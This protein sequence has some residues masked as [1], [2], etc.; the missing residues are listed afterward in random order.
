MGRIQFTLCGSCSSEEELN[1]Y[2]AT[3]PPVRQEILSLIN[4]RP[5]TPEEIAHRLGLPRE[6]VLAHLEG[7][8][9]PGLVERAGL[10]YKPSFAIFTAEDQAKL[11]PLIDKLSSVFAE[12]VEQNI[13]RVRSTYQ[14]CGFQEHGLSFGDMAYILVGAYTLDYG[15][16]KFL[17][18]AGFLVVSKPMPG[19]NYIFSG[20]E[21]GP[22]LRANWQWGHSRKFGKFTFFGHGELPQEGPR[23]AFP[24]QAY[25][26]LKGGHPEEEVAATMEELGQILL[27]LYEGPLGM[28]ELLERTGLGK[29]EFE[30]RLGLLQELEYISIDGKLF[31][32]SCPVLGRE[33]LEHIWELA[34]GLQAEF[35]AG[36]IEPDWERLER[37]YQETAPARN[38][39]DL[40][41][42]FN[43]IYHLIFERA[44]RLLFEKG[45]I[46]YP[47]R[48]ADGARYAV[49]LEHEEGEGER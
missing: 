46:P 3:E 48:H 5:R 1:P 33:A 22:D 45:I 42:A 47:K 41:E 13:D 39:I 34:E 11:R 49:W 32:S 26:W 40:R 16:L 2:K 9:R 35:I 14:A 18:E 27:A 29:G 38:G 4:L 8:E 31:V 36:A 23:R 19:G 43:L 24:E 17:S 15:G 6:E 12:V 10:R 30:E 28:E 7:L 37:I 25:I 44:L 21:D 20:L